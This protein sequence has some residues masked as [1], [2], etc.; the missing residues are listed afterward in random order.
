LNNKTILKWDL[1]F[2]AE[3]DFV[4]I[5]ISSP[6]KDYRL[7]HFINK[8]TL[9]NFVRGKEDKFDHN[10]KLKQK[11]SEE[12]EYH[13]VFDNAKKSKQHFTTFWY[14][15]TK[16]QTEYY[17]INNKSIEGNLLIPE[18][19]N[20]DYFIIIKNYIDDDDLDRIVKNINKIP[21]VVFVKEISPKILKSK[22]NL[23]F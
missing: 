10:Q 4:L 8:L 15:N 11:T 22:E 14:I 6:L 20:F 1:E 5:A 13:I 3:L 16:F 7:C 19:P 21:E 23:I 2:D 17:L 12:L 9:L 18:H